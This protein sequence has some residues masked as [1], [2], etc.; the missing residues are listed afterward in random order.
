MVMA[1]IQ[2]S[3]II[4]VISIEDPK[5]THD[6][7]YIPKR[8]RPP[9]NEILACNNRWMNMF[10][11]RLDVWINTGAKRNRKQHRKWKTRNNKQKWHNKIWLSKGH[12]NMHMMSTHFKDNLQRNS[13]DSDSQPHMFDDG[14]STSITNGLQDFTIKPTPIMRKVKG[15]A[16]SAKATYCRTVKWKIEDNNNIIHM[17]TIPNTYYIANAP[18]RILSP[19]HFAQQMQD[20]K[21]HKIHQDSQT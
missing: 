15:I 1:A 2:V 20:H 14:A 19:Q 8:K 13:F 16:G 6:M 18:T 21:P 3:L 4:I 7:P 10:C 11:M 5:E 12:C 17:F 9:R